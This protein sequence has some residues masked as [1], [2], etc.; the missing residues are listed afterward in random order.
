MAK[1]T[2]MEHLS[3]V[4]YEEDRLWYPER[5]EDYEEGNVNKYVDL[6]RD[7]LWDKEYEK[8]DK[9]LNADGSEIKSKNMKI[10]KLKSKWRHANGI[11][12]KVIAITNETDTEKYPLTIVYKG[13]NGKVWSRPLSDWYRSFT[14][15]IK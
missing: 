15:I 12:Y 14:E 1:E 11:K 8:L 4:S 2:M 3:R 6:N 9:G 13:K 5:L 10:P 7:T